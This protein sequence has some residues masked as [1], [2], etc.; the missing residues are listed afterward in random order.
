VGTWGVRLYDNDTACDVRDQWLKALRQGASV[1]EATAEVVKMF[2]GFED[3]LVWLALADTQWTWGRLDAQVLKRAQAAL[4]AG[5]DLELWAESPER[6]ARVRVLERLAARLNQPPPSPKPIRVRGDAVDWRRGQLWAYHT[7]DDRY[8]VLRVVAFDP[9]YGLAGAPVTELLDMVLDDLP[10]KVSLSAISVRPARPDYNASGRYD[11]V[12]APDHSPMFEPVVKRRGELPRHR[13][14]RIRAQGEPRSGTVETPTVGVPWDA[15]DDFL[16]RTFD[17]GGPRPGAV[18]PWQMPDG[19]VAYTMVEL[20]QWEDTLIEPQWQ[21]AVLACRG[22][23]VPAETILNARVVT[24]MIV[25]GFPPDTLREVAYRP[26]ESADAIYGAVYR[27]DELTND[28]ARK[29]ASTR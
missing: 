18:F 23:D 11:A 22:A 16:S 28:I 19:D 3:P 13:L 24:R 4:A 7:L 20:G 14:R 6:P 9:S 2:D 26:I 12:H 1:A 17:L 25:S 5:G 29:L 10:P 8:A 21:L 27:W 15:M